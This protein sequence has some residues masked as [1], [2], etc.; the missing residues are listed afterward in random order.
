MSFIIPFFGGYCYGLSLNT[1]NPD[2][3]KQTIDSPFLKTIDMVSKGAIY[4]ITAD[5]V[6]R[7]F[8]PEHGHKAFTALLLGIASYKVYKFCKSKFTK[9]GSSSLYDE[10]KTLECTGQI[11]CECIEIDLVTEKVKEE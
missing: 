7:T 9:S 11:E 5:V 8:I 3:V 4:G 2:I 1:D 10:E 6:S